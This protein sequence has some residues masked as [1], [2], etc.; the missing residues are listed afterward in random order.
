MNSKINTPAAGGGLYDLWYV[1]Q[2]DL[3]ETRLLQ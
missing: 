1:L 2:Y 3:T